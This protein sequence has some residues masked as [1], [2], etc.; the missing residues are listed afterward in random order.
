MIKAIPILFLF[1]MAANAKAQIIRISTTPTAIQYQI[2]GY[3]E[4]STITSKVFSYTPST[5][6]P[7]TTSVDEDSTTEDDKLYNYADNI[8]VSINNNDGNITNTS[9]GK[10]WTLKISVPN[11]L[12]IGFV[13]N[14]FSLSS[15]AEMYIFNEEK[16]A[17]DSAIMK[18]HFGV[19]SQ[20]GI[21]PFNSNSVIIYIIEPNNFESFQSSISIQKLEAGFQKITDVDNNA[22][23]FA[24]RASINCDPMILCQ[25]NKITSAGSVARFFSNGFQGTGT[26]INNEANNGRAYFLTAFHVLDVNRNIFNKPVGNGVL[27]PDEIAALANARFQFQ[28]WRTTCNGTVNNRFIQFNG[29]VVRAS[30]PNTD[31][32]L[33]ELI[34][35]PGVGDGVN[36]SGWNRQTNASSD[37]GSYIIHHPQGEDMRIT[38]TKKV[39]NWFWNNLYWTAKYNSGTDDRGSS[40]SALFNEKAQIVGQLRSGWSSCNFTDF[41]DRYG[42][43]NHSWNGAG[44]QPWLSPIKV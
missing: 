30:W 39:K 21:S 31:V 11:A 3:T 44:L 32:V 15:T 43:F 23:N 22:G 26:L 4:V 41:G 17:L 24:L 10:V 35:G 8:S 28:F 16:T 19:N 34:D 9:I 42:K 12:N 2:P 5:P 29:A 18:S 14:Q 40:G 25:M 20:I 36:Y 38:N 7:Y 1:V 33:L 13:F 37:Y 6:Q 27:D